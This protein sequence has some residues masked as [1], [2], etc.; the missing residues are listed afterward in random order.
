MMAAFCVRDIYT[1]YLYPRFCIRIAIKFTLFGLAFVLC[2]EY[3][4]RDE[5]HGVP[6]LVL[7]SLS[8]PCFRNFSFKRLRLQNH[9]RAC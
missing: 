4:T 9:T 8:H 6:I 5:M 2:C 7:S 3:V 1:I